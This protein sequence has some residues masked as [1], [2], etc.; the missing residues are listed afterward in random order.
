LHLVDF[1]VGGHR[2]LRHQLLGEREVVGELFLVGE[3][4]VELALGKG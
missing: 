3:V 4:G 2:I 1:G